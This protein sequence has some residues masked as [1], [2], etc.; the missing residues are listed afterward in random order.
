MHRNIA[1]TY[2]PI[3]KRIIFSVNPARKG[4]AVADY[5]RIPEVMKNQADFFGRCQ[6]K[7]FRFK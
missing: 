3:F 7:I 2:K 1:A 5:T 4:N 6:K